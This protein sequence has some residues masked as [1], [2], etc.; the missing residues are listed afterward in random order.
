MHDKLIN[1]V[2]HRLNESESKEVRDWIHESE[3]NR[4][5]FIRL[6]NVYTLSGK[7]IK[8]I[9]VDSDFLKLK[10]K[11]NLSKETK[12]FSLI[13]N[14]LKYAAIVIFTLLIGYSASRFISV[15]DRNEL[16]YNELIV[17]LGQISEFILS[18]GTHVWLNSGT[19]F[20]FPTEFGDHKREIY[21]EGEAYFKVSKDKHHPFLVNSGQMVT[22]VLGTE[23][24]VSAYKN[25]DEI[26][27]TLIEGSV[28]IL[29]TKHKKI[30][31][32]EPEQQFVYSNSKQIH[33][34]TQVDT[35]PFEAWKDGELVFRNKTLEE[36]KP[37]LER[38]Y[39]V[40]IEFQDEISKNYRFSGT[41]LKQKPVDQI[42]QVIQVF[43]PIDFQVQVNPGAKNDIQIYSL[44]K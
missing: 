43:I 4:K 12:T 28:E 32:L 30:V 31:R 21:L 22:R 27:T 24:N 33:T 7:T 5:E 29:N 15:D 36:I 26:E 3:D 9:S 40:N 20:R 42:L 35:K 2:A 6:K 44:K 18:D 19:K 10:K 8:G 39:N 37:K 38:W 13:N 17:P 1:Y 16:S 11:L 14:M 23:F 41:L 34:V 25:S